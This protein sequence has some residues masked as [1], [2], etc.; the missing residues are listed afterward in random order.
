MADTANQTAID[1]KHLNWKYVGMVSFVAAIGG[2]LFGFDTG[3]IAGTISGVTEAFDLNA[4]QQGFVVSNLVIACIIGAF[5]T[6]P[7]TDKLGRKKML[8][9]AGFF[10]AA[11]AILSGIPQNFWQL[12]FARF[13][14]GLGV[15]I[16]SVLSPLYIAELAP[17]RVRG[18][19]V[20]V[21]QL[22]IVVGILIT[23]ITN[24]LL[25]DAGANNWR[26]MF[27][28]EAVPALLFTIALFFIPESPRWLSKNGR[29]DEARDV[30]AKVGG[31]AYAEQ[32]MSLV[33]NSL[34]NEEGGLSE[35][36][37]PKLKQVLFIGFIL[38]TFA[39]LNG[40][41]AI[42][43]YGTEIFT[44]V[45]GAGDAASAAS[46][47]FKAQMIVGLTNLIFTFLGMAMIDK[48]GRKFLHVLAYG[49]MTVSMLAFGI[50]FNMEN[51]NPILKV[52]PILL[53]VAAFASG[54]GVVIWVYL[55]EIFPNKVRG[56]AMGTATMLVWV[57]NFLTSQFYP[58]LENAMGS[59]V[60]F[61]FTGVCLIAF[62]FA[63]GMMKETKGLQLEET[64]DIFEQ[65]SPW[66]LRR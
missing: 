42:I 26:W 22:A 48:F 23:Y 63:L 33:S 15:G 32:E 17:A 66:R 14:G 46:N 6:G 34:D 21:N 61:L 64:G 59:N 55:S 60:F 8:I 43:Y 40:I 12:V 36:L 39:N 38:A 41:N 57:A 13:I 62:L 16:A 20:A 47:S 51:I 54:V 24:L 1:E 4:W 11:S 45:F 44:S 58:V 65:P 27:A 2:L 18:R 52:V 3:V 30:F 19:L 5:A 10:F 49:A 50:M 53:Y 28:V 37:N 25:L 31:D 7:I 9:T 35:L 56:V 29:D